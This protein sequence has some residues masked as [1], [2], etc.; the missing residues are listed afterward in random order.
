MKNK[1]FTLIELLVVIV[2]IGILATISTAT[3]GSSI[4]KSRDAQRL[5][6]VSDINKI[7]GQELFL[8][9][10]TSGAS[11]VDSFT[12]GNSGTGDKIKELLEENGVKIK[13]SNDTCYWFGYVLDYNTNK[14]EYAA[15]T[16]GEASSTADPNQAGLI[17]EGTPIAK[18][19]L[20]LAETGTAT[21]VDATF[22]LRKETL[23]CK[24]PSDTNRLAFQLAGQA[25][26]A[27]ETSFGSVVSGQSPVFFNADG[28]V[29]LDYIPFNG[30]QSCI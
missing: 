26:I 28:E 15:I 7:L 3:F 17:V 19:N 2:I 8:L 4:K 10:E 24:N 9:V 18:A 1:A 6:T 12:Y 23:E 27:G 14:I 5:Q 13:P 25:G 11:S 21:N 20:L 22:D 30:G 29:C 16:W